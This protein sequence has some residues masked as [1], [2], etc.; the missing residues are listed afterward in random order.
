[1][2]WLPL[3]ASGWQPTTTSTRTCETPSPWQRSA[4]EKLWSY[5]GHEAGRV[6]IKN[7]KV[8]CHP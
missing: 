8:C 1:M 5:L 7:A 3:P 6:A 2:N 4:P